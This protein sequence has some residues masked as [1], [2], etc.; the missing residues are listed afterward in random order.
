[1][2]RLREIAM[3]LEL[4]RFQAPLQ[5]HRLE[6]RIR[7][8]SE[9]ALD[10]LDGPTCEVDIRSLEE[11]FMPWFEFVPARDLEKLTCYFLLL[12]S[13][14]RAIATNN[15]LVGHKRGAGHGLADRNENVEAERSRDKAQQSTHRKVRRTLY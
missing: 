10:R 2:L 1:V 8:E 4:S 15:R 5:F 14:S 12:L 11:Q 7:A 6:L 3:T 13:V 9:S